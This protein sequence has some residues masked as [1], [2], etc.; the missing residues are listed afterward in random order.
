MSRIKQIT[1]IHVRYGSPD[2]TISTYSGKVRVYRYPSGVSIA[3][4]ADAIFKLRRLKRA[5]VRPFLAHSVGYVAW[6][7]HFPTLLP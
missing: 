6:I 7:D 2:V 5:R 4:L 1:V 3:R